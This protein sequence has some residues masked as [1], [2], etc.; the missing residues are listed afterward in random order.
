[1]TSGVVFLYLY[2][3][4]RFHYDY[5]DSTQGEIWQSI[6]HIDRMV[7]PISVQVKQQGASTIDLL[8]LETQ[9]VVKLVCSHASTWNGATYNYAYADTVKLFVRAFVGE[10]FLQ[11]ILLPLQKEPVPSRPKYY[12]LRRS[13]SCVCLVQIYGM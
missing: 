12:N 2:S 1:M 10:H 13:R 5:Y 6:E 8:V 9:T 3:G 7:R 11:F 4:S